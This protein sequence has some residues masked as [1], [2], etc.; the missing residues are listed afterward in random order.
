M[1]DVY[2][3][4]TEAAK[5][6]FAGLDEEGTAG[7]EVVGLIRHGEGSFR[8]EEEVVPSTFDGFSQY[9]FGAAAAIHI[10]RIE[11][12]EASVEANVD[13]PGG[14]FDLGVAPG[15]EKIVPPAEGACAEAENRYTETGMAELSIF[16]RSY[17]LQ[18]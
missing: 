15:F 6:V 9:F 7:A 11:E 17:F 16:H 10:G 2:V 1:I 13:Q 18:K 8:G 3:V 4:D 14:L 5:A 12:V